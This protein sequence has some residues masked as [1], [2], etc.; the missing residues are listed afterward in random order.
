ML[1]IPGRRYRQCDGVTRRDFL[2]IGSLAMGGLSLPQVLEA[3][4][5]SGSRSSQKAVILVYLTGGPPHIDTVDP[6]PEAPDEIRGHFKAIESSVSGIRV[7]EHMPRMARMMDKFAIV[8]SMVGARDE[9]ASDMSLVG[10]AMGEN[11]TRFHPSLGSVVSKLQGPVNKSI[12]PFIDARVKTGHMP[13]SNDAWPGF[14][15]LSH[16]ALRTHGPVQEDMTLKGITLDRLSDRRRLLTSLDRFRREADDSGMLSQVSGVQARAMDLLTDSRLAKALDYSKEPEKVQALY[17]K[18]SPTP[19]QDAS[20]MWNEQFLIA[21]RLVE[22]GARVVT[23]GFGSWDFHSPSKDW[24]KNMVERFDQSISALVQ[25]LHDRGMDKDV[26]VAAWGDF[27]RSPK[28]GGYMNN[29]AAL[30]GREHW[31]AVAFGI[32]AGGGMRTG[33]VIG[34]TNR[35]GEYADERPVHYRDAFATLY[36]NLGIDIHKVEL[37]DHENRPYF[38]LPGH[39]PIAELI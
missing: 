28:L 23:I 29:Y 16:A 12:P 18:G 17:G 8:R 6:K 1:T 34:S 11:R 2:K 38:L 24:I 22:A 20:P 32:L 35:F 15:G 4:E 13:Y 3:Q 14:L 10:Y 7:S 36:H 39:E 5:L 21:R 27:G 25:D 30:G 33:Q 37:R 9:H 26:T 19:V 31:P